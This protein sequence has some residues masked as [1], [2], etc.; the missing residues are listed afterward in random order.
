MT[1]LVSV[2]H[3]LPKTTIVAGVSGSGKSAALRRLVAF[4]DAGF[5]AAHDETVR[6]ARPGTLPGV[7]GVNIAAVATGRTSLDLV[8]QLSRAF[9]V[10]QPPDASLAARVERLTGMLTSRDSTT[11]VIDALDEAPD[12]RSLVAEVLKPLT[13]SGRMRL[14]VGVRG[15]A[16]AERP[17]EPT[18]LDWTAEML[19]ADVIAVDAPPY[20]ADEDLVDYADILLRTAL[21]ERDDEQPNGDASRQFAARIATACGKSFLLTTLLASD[22]AVGTSGT[23]L[24][25]HGGA[26]GVAAAL[27]EIVTAEL[28]SLLDSD[29]RVRAV[30]LLRAVAISFGLGVP[31]RRIW[32]KIATA[33]ADADAQYGDADVRWLLQQRVGGYLSRDTDGDVTVYRPFHAELGAALSRL[34]PAGEDPPAEL[35]EMHRRVFDELAPLAS[36]RVIGGATVPPDWY[37]ARYLAEH[38][39]AAGRLDDALSD[40]RSV[41]ASDPHRLLT[42]LGQARSDLARS[43]AAAYRSSAPA[44]IGRSCRERASILEF[45]ARQQDAPRVAEPLAAAFPD[46]P[47]TT[48]WARWTQAPPHVVLANDVVRTIGLAVTRLPLGLAV[49]VAEA[50]GTVRALD[51]ETGQMLWTAHLDAPKCLSTAADIV[52]V[53]TASEIVLLDAATGSTRQVVAWAGGEVKAIALT[54][55]SSLLAAGNYP[56]PHREAGPAIVYV[57]ERSADGS[58]F[59][60]LWSAPAFQAGIL[61]L[62]WRSNDNRTE[63]VVGGD[64]HKQP[65]TDLNLARVFHGTTGT[66]IASIPSLRTVPA[67]TR[68]SPSGR[69]VTLQGWV[70]KSLTWWKTDDS[71]PEQTVA[72]TI[73]GGT[74]TNVWDFDGQ[75][76]AEAVIG[77]TDEGICRIE[78][79]RDS[80]PTLLAYEPKVQALTAADGLLIAASR[81][82]ALTRWDLNQMSHFTARPVNISR[83]WCAQA[84]SLIFST[85]RDEPGGICVENAMTGS[86]VRRYTYPLLD[87]YHWTAVTVADE[88]DLLLVGDRSGRVHG[89]RSSAVNEEVFVWQIHQEPEDHANGVNSIAVHEDL[90]VTAGEDGAVRFTNWRTGQQ[91]LPPVAHFRDEPGMH[92]IVVTEADGEEA[93]LAGDRFGILLSWQMSSLSPTALFEGFST[94]RVTELTEADRDLDVSSLTWL[95]QPNGLGWVAIPSWGSGHIKVVDIAARSEYRWRA[96][97]DGVTSLCDSAGLLYSADSHGMVRCWA[98][99]REGTPRLLSELATNSPMIALL[100]LANKYIAIVSAN[101]LAVVRCQA[102]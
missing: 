35:T 55:E 13:E 98:G 8:D 52:A 12:S 62:S 7:G 30:T 23:D 20:W 88:H 83:A 87:T 57:W 40:P 3:G 90:L 16:L 76:G 1:D 60:H 58:V 27:A 29:D 28:E 66:L 51:L 75:I 102:H 42:L 101:G 82:G 37:I 38:A 15:A 49:V 21:S 99:V 2:A 46:R 25:E 93:I 34:A 18:L 47:W 59:T 56:D 80:K 96:H 91:A 89:W 64:P 63:L 19:K 5:R 22:P 6:D 92:A 48:R 53:G 100:S 74:N 95:R 32:P 69:I 10:Q 36:E 50:S 65:E 72:T 78:M 45:T 71:E 44:L 67:T 97:D 43:I 14:I 77:T 24:I 26:P 9:G 73:D 11:V 94:A 81:S 4:S 79:S 84:G 86:E 68:V 39:A 54:S 41:T 85:P 33:I 61:S 17:D 70:N 31:R